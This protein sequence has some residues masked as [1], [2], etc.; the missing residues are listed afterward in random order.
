MSLP[1]LHAASQR[2]NGVQVPHKIV[3]KR[4]GVIGKVWADPTKANK[5]RGWKA[6]TPSEDTMLSAWNWQKK[7]RERGLM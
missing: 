7:L 4:E 6:E 1:Q 2:E 5:V 3:R